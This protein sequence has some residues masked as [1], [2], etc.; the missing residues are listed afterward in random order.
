MKVIQQKEIDI[1]KIVFLGK[2]SN[3]QKRKQGKLYLTK[4]LLHSSRYIR[5][6]S[7]YLLR[8]HETN[9]S[10]FYCLIILLFFIFLLRTYIN[11]F[12]FICFSLYIAVCHIRLFIICISSSLHQVSTPFQPLHQAK[13]NQNLDIIMQNMNRDIKIFLH[14]ILP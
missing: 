3:I 9:K 6:L 5:Q 11:S 13:C 10:V 14:F 12:L 7:F 2:G 4:T 8:C 1:I